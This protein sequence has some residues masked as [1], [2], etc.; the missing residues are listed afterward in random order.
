[1]RRS[2]ALVHNILLDFRSSVL[3]KEADLKE[4]GKI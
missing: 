1:V 4:R 2:V 3:R